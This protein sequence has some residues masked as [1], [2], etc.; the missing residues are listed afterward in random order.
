MG[1]SSGDPNGAFDLNVLNEFQNFFVKN[2]AQQKL[3][4]AASVVDMSYAD[5]AVQWLGKA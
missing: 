1:L 2:G 3:L 5:A 4:D